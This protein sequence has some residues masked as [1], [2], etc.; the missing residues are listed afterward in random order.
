MR[1]DD[2]DLA[3]QVEALELSLRA[4]GRRINK[5]ESKEASEPAPAPEIRTEPVSPVVASKPAPE[6]VFVA[7]PAK[8]PAQMESVSSPRS[9]ETMRHAA[10]RRSGRSEMTSWQSPQIVRSTS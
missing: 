10:A 5:L 8:P 6:P 9:L 1:S 4:L 2:A 3:K 7:P